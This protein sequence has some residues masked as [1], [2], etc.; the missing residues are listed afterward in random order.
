M[1]AVRTLILLWSLILSVGASDCSVRSAHPQLCYAAPS[2]LPARALPVPTPASSLAPLV[3]LVRAAVVNVDVVLRAEDPGPET[4]LEGLFERKEA[5]G[6]DPHP[7]NPHRGAGS[8]FIIDGSGLVLTNDHVVDSASSI[9]VRLDD[10]RSFEGTLLGRDPLTDLAL[11]KLKGKV[12][13]LPVVHLGDSD[14][15]KVGEWVMAIGNP[16]GLSSSVSAGILSAR[17]RDLQAGPFDDFFQTD[18]AIN[19]GNSGGP[20]FNVRGEVIGLNTA[21]VSGGSGI[22]FA[23]PSNIIRALLPQ[24]QQGVIH[25][26]WLGVSIQDLTPELAQALKVPSAHG[27][28]IAGVGESTPAKRGSLRPDDVVTEINGA[29]IDTPKAF[30]RGISFQRPGTDVTLTVYRDGKRLELSFRL[31]ERPD[32]EK[33]ALPGP[34]PLPLV[35]R[36]NQ[37]LGMTL[38]DLEANHPEESNGAAR[39]AVIVRVDPGSPSDL[40]RLEEGM[41]VVEAAGQSVGGAR[42][43]VQ[44]LHRSHPGAMVLVRVQVAGGR[45][46]KALQKP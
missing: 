45:L 21:I 35:E 32:A 42:D 27:A 30:T 1:T 12:I 36:S 29:T 17:E 5:V 11:I 18:A 24:L 41:V 23:I 4:L 33:A 38:K 9:R 34:R 8:G 6:D 14:E 44:A 20:L 37:A 26:G 22:G 3:D 16:F 13:D 43:L 15:M 7:D 31:G 40:A 19:P 10:G 25:R 39:G 46:L 28:V 2:L